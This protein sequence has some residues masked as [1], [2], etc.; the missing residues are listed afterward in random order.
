MDI[1][2]AY[3]E[4]A[5]DAVENPSAGSSERVRVANVETSRVVVVICVPLNPPNA[6]FEQRHS[7]TK[8]ARS[9]ELVVDLYE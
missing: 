6:S 8:F 4:D 2:E 3:G 1:G 9:G 5:V 7:S